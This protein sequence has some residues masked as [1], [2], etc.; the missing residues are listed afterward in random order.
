MQ[1]VATEHLDKTE[2]LGHYKSRQ[3]DQ[4]HD[5]ALLALSLALLVTQA[6]GC[7]ADDKASIRVANQDHLSALVRE[8]LDLG[9]HGGGVVERSLGWGL[10]PYR[11]IRHGTRLPTLGVQLV[12]HELVA[13][14][15]V[16]GAR[17]EDENR[18]CVGR[19]CFIDCDGRSVGCGDRILAFLSFRDWQNT[20]EAGTSFAMSKLS[21]REQTLLSGGGGILHAN[22]NRAF[23]LCNTGGFISWLQMPERGSS[24]TLS[25][26]VACLSDAAHASH[27]DLVY[28]RP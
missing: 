14:W 12:L 3:E 20:S 6:L 27:R 8:S 7:L 18:F 17:G 19:H 1:R 28:I 13:V 2:T 25:G 10:G 16:P 5:T 22:T 23:G 24:S 21:N 9:T 15:R 4:E 26:V 11:R